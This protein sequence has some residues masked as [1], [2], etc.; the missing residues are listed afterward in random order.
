MPEILAKVQPL[1]ESY[2]DVVPLSV[3]EDI[4]VV[5]SA[6]F[7]VAPYFEDTEEL[8]LIVDWGPGQ[9]AHVGGRLTI[10]RCAGRLVG[11][12]LA[13]GLDG[14]G[15]WEGTLSSMAATSDRIKALVD[16]PGDVVVVHEL[17][18]DADYRGQGIAKSCLALVLDNR[19]ESNVVLGVYEQAEDARVMYDRWGF[20]DLGGTDIQDGAVRMRVLAAETE[21]LRLF[22]ENSRQAK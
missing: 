17:A 2:N 7:S 22:T 20:Q 12:A 1:Y 11:F 21:Q 4:A 14:D 9:V 6:A 16:G 10:A 8:A 13:H 5:F 15:S 19:V 3:W 18:V